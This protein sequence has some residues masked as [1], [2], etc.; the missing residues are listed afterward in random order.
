MGTGISSL[1]QALNRLDSFV[2]QQRLMD[3]LSTQLLQVKT[4]NLQD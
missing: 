1:A 2:S 4:R 3:D